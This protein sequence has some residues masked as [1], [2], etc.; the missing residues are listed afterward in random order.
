M[1]I[2]IAAKPI[3]IVAKSIPIVAKSIMIAAK[4]TG[5]TMWIAIAVRKVVPLEVERT[6]V[7]VNDFNRV[8]DLIGMAESFSQA[9]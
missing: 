1:R 9:R 3:A 7:G 2:A 4:P 6:A 5:V 8:T